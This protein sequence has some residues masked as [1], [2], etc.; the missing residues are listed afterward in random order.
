MKR[1]LQAL[2]VL[3]GIWLLSVLTIFI[4]GRLGLPCG[5][6]FTGTYHGTHME[7]SGCLAA[8]IILDLVFAYV[9]LK[10][11]ASLPA[12]PAAVS[13]AAATISTSLRTLFLGQ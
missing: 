1:V 4:L 7:A 6:L 13:H 9:F 12:V 2:L 3:F 8:I 5:A 10:I 11:V